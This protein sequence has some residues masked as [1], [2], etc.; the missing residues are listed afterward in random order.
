[1]RPFYG[2]YQRDNKNLPK[3]ELMAAKIQ[4]MM[5]IITKKQKEVASEGLGWKRVEYW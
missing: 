3:N 5:M 1:M 4:V 2:N